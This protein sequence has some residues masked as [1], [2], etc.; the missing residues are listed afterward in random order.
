MSDDQVI[1][2]KVKPEDLEKLKTD[3]KDKEL[4][5]I[6]EKSEA[7]DNS[8]QALEARVGALEAI[9]IP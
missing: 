8:L 7:T 9:V 2:V 1:Y 4:K 3:L 6:K 5:D